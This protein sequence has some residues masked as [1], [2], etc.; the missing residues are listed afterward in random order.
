MRLKRSK[1]SWADEWVP[2]FAQAA[3]PRDLLLPCERSLLELLDPVGLSGSQGLE[4][5][6]NGHWVRLSALKRSHAGNNGFF[7]V[8]YTLDGHSSIPD[9]RTSSFKVVTQWF[10]QRDA[11]MRQTALFAIACM[12]GT[13]IGRNELRGNFLDCGTHRIYG[14]R[15]DNGRS[16]FGRTAGMG[17]H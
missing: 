10:A 9:S 16:C 1:P 2:G 8:P 15:Q 12:R 13:R 4:W 3:N 11:R 5:L 14:Q 17:V 6:L 7:G